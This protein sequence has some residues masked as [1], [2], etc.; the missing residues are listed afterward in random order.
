MPITVPLIAHVLKKFDDFNQ[1]HIY[2]AKPT[3][4]KGSPGSFLA[5]LD[6]HAQLSLCLNYHKT[7]WCS[8]DES[9]NECKFRMFAGFSPNAF[10]MEPNKTPPPPLNPEEMPIIYK[11]FVNHLCGSLEKL[12]KTIIEKKNKGSF[13]RRY[14]YFKESDQ[15]LEM[16]HSFEG[17]YEFKFWLEYSKVVTSLS[18]GRRARLS[19]VGTNVHKS[20]L[21]ITQDEFLERIRCIFNDAYQVVV[22]ER[23]N[24]CLQGK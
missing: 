23:F 21:T 20:G 4:P 18:G 19:R 5:H 7:D 12:G 22:E 24:E 15:Y 9:T 8:W 10:H 1:I 3:F 11:S 17:N 16:S 2:P 14:F 6:T 13:D